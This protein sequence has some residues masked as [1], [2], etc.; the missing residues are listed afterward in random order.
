MTWLYAFQFALPLILIGWLVWWPARSGLG[1]VVQVF[2]SVAALAVMALQGV[3]LL[4][5]WWAPF[6]FAVALGVAAWLVR[7]RIPPF[8]SAVPRTGSAWTV[9]VLFAVLGATSTCGA[10]HAL[11]SRTA[12]AAG[13]VNLAFPIEP[14]RYLVVNGSE[15]PQRLSFRGARWCCC[16]CCH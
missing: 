5:P 10:V 6:V 14:D 9:M 11:R 8:S 1:F 7:R 4:P 2:G 12:P 13:V 16:C 3:W 15:E